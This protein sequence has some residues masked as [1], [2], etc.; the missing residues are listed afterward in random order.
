MR[1]DAHRHHVL[2]AGAVRAL[3]R[4][5]RPPVD[6]QTPRLRTG[7]LL[8]P[9]GR[10]PNRAAHGTTR[11]ISM[12]PVQPRCSPDVTTTSR[13]AENP[14]PITVTGSPGCT[15]QATSGTSIS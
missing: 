2:R 14:A 5:D 8:F 4:Q 15:K 6:E 1:G 12:R 7:A 9:A 10:P 11:S 13:V 3:T